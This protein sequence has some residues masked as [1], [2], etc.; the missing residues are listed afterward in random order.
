MILSQFGGPN[1]PTYLVKDR[2]RIILLP[3]K[4]ILVIVPSERKG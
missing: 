1:R 3:L 2:V 4:I